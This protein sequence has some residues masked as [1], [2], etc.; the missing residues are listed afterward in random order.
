[1]K[2]HALRSTAVAFALM[3]L[4]IGT[5]RLHA[6]TGSIKGTIT[7]SETGFPMAGASI[8]IPGTP[9]GAEADFDG[10]YVLIGITPGTYTLEASFTGYHNL[11][12]TN[13]LVESDLTTTLDIT[14]TPAA[15]ELKEVKVV[16][17]KKLVNLGQS[18]AGQRLGK[19][20]LQNRKPES[21]SAIL[22]TTKGFKTDV[23]GK[24]HVRGSRSGSVAIVVDDIDRRDPLVDTQTSL[25]VSSEAVEEINILTGGFNAEYGRAGAVVQITTSEGSKTD[26][27]GR[28]EFQTDRII[29]TY[30][31]DT[32]RMEL[33]LGGPVPY[34]KSLL[35]KPVTF[36]L[37]TTGYLSNT[38]TPFNINRPANDYLGLGIKLPERQDN[39]YQTS[40]KLSYSLTDTKKLSLSLSENYHR[41]DIYPAGEGGVSG[42]YGYGYKYN[43]QNRPWAE[44]R[45]FSA[46]LTYTNQ[47]SAK[48]YYTL[49]LITFSTHSRVQPRGKSPGEFTLLSAIENNFANAFDRNGNSWLDPD[50]YTDNDGNGFMDGFWDANDNGIYDGGGEGYE[51]LN[52]NGQ[53]DRGEDWVDLNG[54][55]IYD[56]AEP[57]VDVVNPLT[58]E[59]NPGQWDPWDPYVD[60][61]G[62]GRW[63][64]DEPQLP[65]QD[66]NRN[67]RWDGERFQDANGNGS[68]D[69]WEPFTD[70]NGNSR[71]DPGE[72]FED[73]NGNG[74]QDDGEG[75][76]DKDLSGENNRR[77][78]VSRTGSSDTREPFIDGDYWHD[79]GE[80]FIDEPDPISGLYNGRWDPGEIWFDLPS[81]ANA[82]TGAGRW[83]LGSEMTLNGRYDPP[84]SLFD[85]YELFCKPA[86]FRSGLNPSRPVIYNYNEEARGNDWPDNI[87][88]FIP[89]KSTW[90]NRSLHDAAAPLFNIPNTQFDEG[91]EWFRDYNNN[92]VWDNYDLFLNPGLWDGTAF[93][94]DRVATEYTV[95]YDIQSQVTK[96]HEMKSGVE[97][98]YRDLEMQSISQPDLLYSGEANLPSGSLYPDRGGVRDFYQYQPFEGAAY[99]QD[100]MEFE[101]LIVN[102]GLRLDFIIHDQKVIDEFRERLIRDEPG[103]IIAERGNYRV[104][105]RLGISH[106]ITERSKLYFNYG[107]F[108]QAPSFQYFY[109]SA[110]ANFDANTTI[111]NPNLEYEKTIQ[112][113]LGVNT[114]ISDFVVFDISGYYKDQYDLI[115][116][117]DERWKNLTL[118]R[119]V[120]LD[121]G[122]MRGF[123]FTIDK[124]PAHHYALTF[125]YDFSYAFGKASDQLANQ[126]SRLRGV[127]YN[128]DEHPLDWDETH[129]INAFLTVLYAKNEHPELLGFRMPDD[130]L[131]TVQW[132]FGSGLPYTPSKY[133]TGIENTNLILPNSARLPWRERTTLKFEKYYSLN[134]QKGTRAFFGFTVGNLFNKRNVQSVYAETGSPSQAIHPLNPSYNPSENRSNYDANPRNY[135][136][137]RNVL[138]RVGMTF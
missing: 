12:L 83:F 61:N 92:G 31:F 122:R 101:G 57:W 11:T 6:A 111:G 110:T 76:D 127:P 103:A 59:N 72:P 121:Y 116:T 32:D 114:Q 40:L 119:Y 120:N 64:P 34:S 30:S 95:K 14:L 70:L 49:K 5:G 56:A 29:E 94:Q 124:R 16:V 46:A 112:Y 88:A 33:N 36:F 17:Q 85:E 79:T 10:N 2:R 35:G 66:W 7:D 125:N 93:W 47:V 41:W 58:G 107:H 132:E 128:Y 69:A 53:W 134:P 24:F 115:S 8:T 99:L 48:T 133:T 130:W 51:D 80:P 25:S 20:E 50:E 62:N 84:N 129:K 87:Y 135:D 105:P 136:A 37:S 90:I 100:K 54:N 77:D 39:S 60:L 109:K 68:F 98:K 117:A 67:G 55:G 75:Y 63:D 82:Q 91:K 78:L 89:G 106:P 118:D 43:L 123:E 19:V 21:I 96:H 15:I 18:S 138:F 102:A 131:M 27:S 9:W 97:V 4:A 44:N 3:V 38:Y 13:V 137:P 73:L 71:W 104:S 26:Y 126:A 113:E 45:Q 108:Y 1:M 23:E 28:V 86:D 81:S 52:M 74:I 65:E 42:N 22:S